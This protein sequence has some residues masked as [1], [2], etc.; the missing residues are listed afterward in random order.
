M[1]GYRVQFQGRVGVKAEE[2]LSYPVFI[3]YIQ[4]IYPVLT[5]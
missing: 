3:P 2:I 1:G 5:T 4:S